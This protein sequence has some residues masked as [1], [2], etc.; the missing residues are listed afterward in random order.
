MYRDSIRNMGF[1][2][3]VALMLAFWLWKK[4]SRG[5][6]LLKDKSLPGLILQRIENTAQNYAAYV[7]AAWNYGIYT[8]FNDY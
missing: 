1:K 2:L 7:Y 8:Q 6:R 5:V 4:A 3:L